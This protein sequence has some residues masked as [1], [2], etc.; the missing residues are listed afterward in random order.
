[1]NRQGKI[2]ICEIILCILV[3]VA[4]YL[5]ATYIYA[6]ALDIRFPVTLLT[7]W[8]V[9]TLINW[10]EEVR[11]E[12]PKVRWFTL[13]LLASIVIVLFFY[14]PKLTYQEGKDFVARQGYENVYELE[15]RSIIALGLKRTHFVKN[16]Y[17]Y[18]G[19][20]GNTKYYIMLSP[21][22]GEIRAEAMGEGNFLDIYFDM[23]KDK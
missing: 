15:D 4:A 23:I 19:E 8:V 3:Q 12:A 13:L 21:V 20:K 16:A 22:N 11:T 2:L 10:K 6:G 17:L 5:M 18:A 14:K 1:M 9:I 7:N